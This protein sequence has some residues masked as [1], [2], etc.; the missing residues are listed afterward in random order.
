MFL[1]DVGFT[2]RQPPNKSKPNANKSK[3]KSLRFRV[4]RRDERTCLWNNSGA[5]LAGGSFVMNFGRTATDVLRPGDYSLKVDGGAIRIVAYNTNRAC[6]LARGR[7]DLSASGSG[8]GVASGAPPPETKS[9]VDYLRE[10]VPYAVDLEG[11]EAWT[12]ERE[13]KDDLF[14]YNSDLSTVNVDTPWMRIALQ[15]RQ[16]KVPTEEECAYASMSVWIADVSPDLAEDEFDGILGGDPN[17]S[18]TSS[19]SAGTTRKGRA[20][21]RREIAMHQVDGPFGG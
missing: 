21:R 17:G 11:C 7:D 12:A 9:P 10:A 16:N 3:P 2:F 6:S 13:R 19:A 20:L 8:G 4:L 1:G 5:C 18:T 15:V 14:S